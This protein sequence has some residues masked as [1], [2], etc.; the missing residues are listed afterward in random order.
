MTTA[1]LQLDDRIVMV[2]EINTSSR[3]TDRDW[4]FGNILT[5][6]ARKWLIFPTPPLFNA[7][8]LARGEPVRISR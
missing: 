2:E 4:I 1:L 7:P 3:S 5:F 6:K 8:G